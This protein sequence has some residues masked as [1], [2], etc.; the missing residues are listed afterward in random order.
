MRDLKERLQ[1]LEDSLPPRQADIIMCARQR[2]D[3]LE[4][5]ITRLRRWQGAYAR[6]RAGLVE[7][8]DMD[9]EEAERLRHLLDNI[10]Q[11][12][13]DA[14]GQDGSHGF[15]PGLAD[16]ADFLEARRERRP[17]RSIA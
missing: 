11:E 13:R 3:E 14:A 6:G 16:A 12:L 1:V 2:I 15:H 5:G 7:Q 10:V 17:V 9:L 8:A 4:R